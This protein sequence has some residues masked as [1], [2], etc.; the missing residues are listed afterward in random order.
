MQKGPQSPL[1]KFGNADT[2]YL[3]FLWD[4]EGV[5]RRDENWPCENAF[6]AFYA[7]LEAI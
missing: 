5:G 1:A 7:L 3:E 4:Q 2:Y 6:I